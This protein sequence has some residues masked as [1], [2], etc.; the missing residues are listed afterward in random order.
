M[1]AKS[2]AF[3]LASEI[4]YNISSYVV[5]SGIGR[6]LGPAD[7]GRYGVVITLTTTIIILIGNGIPTAMAK[8]LSEIFENKPG[9][10]PVIK[11]KAALFQALLMGSVTL[12]FFLLAPVLAALLKDPSLTPLFRISSL[13]IP[14]FALASFYFS[15]YTGIHKFKV[16]AFLKT[17]RSFSRILFILGFA[18]L[19]K[20]QNLSLEGSVIGFAL[21]PLLV[22]LGAKIYDSLHKYKPS[23]TFDWK[24]LFHYAW[25]ITFFMIAYELLITVDLYLVKGILMSDYHTGIYN[26]A[27]TVGRIPYYLFYALTIIL[28]P[29]VSKATSSKNAAETKKL[30]SQ[31]LR[32][33]VMFLLPICI[34]MSLYSRPIIQL[35]YSR[36]F[37]DAA[38]LM[39]LFVFGVGFLTVFYVLTF[40][41]NGAGKVKVP[42]VISFLGL[43][44]NTIL[45]YVLI[46]KYALW[47]AVVGTTLTSLLVMLII[48]GYSYKFFGYLFKLES[49]IK[50]L[51]GSGALYG[52]SFLFPRDSF[53]FP[54]WSAIL[55][56]FY[57]FLLYILKEFNQF[58]LTL[59]KDVFRRKKEKN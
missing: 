53:L 48:L 56:A 6:I 35:F 36:R 43:L 33:M 47:G 55:L 38:P 18:W 10:I 39:S 40:A 21:A 44:A 37:L 30:I 22:F 31:S 46:A 23:G 52:L 51:I 54:L 8:Y 49:I 42:M 7:Y 12:T 26:A 27:I 59:V 16:Q 41:L 24:K 17:L 45:T 29:A 15:Y 20:P 11:R 9:L 14:T 19:L 1:L 25:P 32:L 50:I 4:V 3:V 57:V 34:L 58:E 2:F 5:H 28:L 13:I